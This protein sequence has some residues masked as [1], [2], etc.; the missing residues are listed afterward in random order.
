M[1][2]KK[3]NLEEPVA[4]CRKRVILAPQSAGRIGKS[5]AA[6]AIVTWM[7][8]A[9]ID[10]VLF[11]LDAEHL[12]ITHRYPELTTTFPD[13]IKSDD[14][15]A[16]FM[17]A[18]TSVDVPALICDLPAQST[19]F[20]LRQL[21]ERNGLGLL[22]ASGV[23]LT[24]LL[25]PVDDTAARQSAVEC[26]R[27]LADRV[28][29]V[30]V[31]QPGP[32]QLVDTTDWAKSKLGMRLASLKAGEIR[33]PQLTRLT[34]EEVEKAVKKENRWMPLSE[35]IGKVGVVPRHE[36]ELWRNHALTGCEDVAH[37]FI[38][39]PALIKKMAV[40]PKAAGSYQRPSGPVFDL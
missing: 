26:V 2:H 27:V 25:F 24:V 21:T 16:R 35:A 7:Q 6:E 28:D 3:S 38:P 8:F 1:M 5:T 14:G 30:V 39:D 20:V 10:N 11:D 32:K 29:W 36:L 33:L 19:D 13:A 34:F 23:R 9:G 37:Y 4:S 40:R 31:W 15:W 18:V 17:A 12:T 22:D